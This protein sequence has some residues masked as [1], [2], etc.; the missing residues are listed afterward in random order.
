MRLIVTQ[1]LVKL[2][3]SSFV[4]QTFD[5]FIEYINGKT[6]KILPHKTPFTVVVYITKQTIF[7]YEIK[8]VGLY[9][10]LGACRALSVCLSDTEKLKH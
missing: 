10:L 4:M 2:C 9:T 1:E 6:R 8:I 7:S 5:S 3:L